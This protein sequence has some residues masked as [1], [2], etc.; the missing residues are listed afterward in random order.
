M[1]RKS[2]KSKRMQS[3]PCLLGAAL[4]WVMCIATLVVKSNVEKARKGRYPYQSPIAQPKTCTKVCVFDIDNTLTSPAC[5]FIGS[6][7]HCLL[8]GD[9]MTTSNTI[10][11]IRKCLENGYCI[12][13]CTSRGRMAAKW[14]IPFLKKMFKAAGFNYPSNFFKSEAFQYNFHEKDKALANIMKLFGITDRKNV[15][16]FDNQNSRIQNAREN[17]FLAQ[18]A[19]SNTHFGLISC[20]CGLRQKEFEK[21]MKQLK[22]R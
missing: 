10:S 14:I 13:V 11:A 17:G 6:R 15:I 16:L 22:M 21:G 3:V 12:S 20:P 7:D 1:H 19:C 2:K 8:M 5:W 4:A 18:E 9:H